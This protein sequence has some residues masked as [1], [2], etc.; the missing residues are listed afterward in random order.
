M[1]QA[2]SKHEANLEHTS[3]TCIYIQ[4][5]WF[6]FASSFK[7]PITDTQSTLTSA[8]WR[9]A[10]VLT[11][12]VVGDMKTNTNATWSS[13]QSRSWTLHNAWESL[14]L[15]DKTGLSRP[16]IGKNCIVYWTTLLGADAALQSCRNSSYLRS[17]SHSYADRLV[18]ALRVDLLWARTLHELYT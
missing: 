18:T 16:A 10:T 14:R 7:H 12:K 5:I 9:P 11:R 3:C 4:N 15:K 6:M 1:K 8:T 2:W 13:L 17:N